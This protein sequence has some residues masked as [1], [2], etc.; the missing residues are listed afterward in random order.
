VPQAFIAS[1][2]EAKLRAQQKE[3]RNR[4]K[5]ERRAARRNDRDK[6]LGV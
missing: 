2:R 4:E 6:S 3:Q 5:R 1:R